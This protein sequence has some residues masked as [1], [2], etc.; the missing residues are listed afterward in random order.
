MDLPIPKH[1]CNVNHDDSSGSMDS[2]L[3]RLILEE[4]TDMTDGRV[5]IGTLVTDDDSTLRSHRRRLG[6]RVKQKEGVP[7]PIFL[8]D[9]SHRVKVMSK[10]IFVMVASTKNQ[11]EIKY[12]DALRLRKY[13]SCYILRHCTCDL[14]SFLRIARALD[15]HLFSNHEFCDTSWC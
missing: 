5:S 1:K 8:V 9:S 14:R 13:T 2:T 12:V 15:E 11:D 4:V 10:P 7:E 3:C 6:N